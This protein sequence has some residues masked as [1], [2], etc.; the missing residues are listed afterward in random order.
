MLLTALTLLTLA[1]ASGAT[2]TPD[3]ELL[4]IEKASIS[5]NAQHLTVKPSHVVKEPLTLEYSIRGNGVEAIEGNVSSGPAARL[6]QVDGLRDQLQNGVEYT[7]EVTLCTEDSASCGPSFIFQYTPTKRF[8]P[9][10]RLQQR[11]KNR[12]YTK[13]IFPTKEL[14][15]LQMELGKKRQERI[16]ARTKARLER[17]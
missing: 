11:V 14:S 16:E 17:Q 5:G 15:K 7:V 12:T 6:L 3:A 10:E 2:S 9:S 4:T 1:T 8:L 13:A